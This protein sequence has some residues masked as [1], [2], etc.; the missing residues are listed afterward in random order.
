MKYTRGGQSHI[1][2]SNMPFCLAIVFRQWT[3][4]SPL[5]IRRGA[6]DNLCKSVDEIHFEDHNY[7][8]L[9]EA[10]SFSDQDSYI[11]EEVQILL[12]C[13][14]SYFYNSILLTSRVA[15]G[16]RLSICNTYIY[17]THGRIRQT[18]VHSFFAISTSTI[19]SRASLSFAQDD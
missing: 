4:S 13:N 1:F 3:S 10:P 2:A 16:K 18:L 12:R 14:E 9:C 17:L 15:S 5:H 7:S 6:P 19:P 8:Q 11:L